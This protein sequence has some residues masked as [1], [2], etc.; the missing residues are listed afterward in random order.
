MA[1]KYQAKMAGY[2]E[3]AGFIA[4][5]QKTLR[6]LGGSQAAANDWSAQYARGR[7]PGGGGT[8]SSSYSGSYRSGPGGGGGAD[9]DAYAKTVGDAY[10][11]AKARAEGRSDLLRSGYR[12]AEADVLGRM[13]GIFDPA[14][15]RQIQRGKERSAATQQDLISKGLSTSTIVPTAQAI[16][17]RETDAALADISSQEARMQSS[18][19]ERIR[20]AGLGQIERENEIYPNLPMH[21][22]AIEDYG[23]YGGGSGSSFSPSG[24]GPAASSPYS[25]TTFSIGGKQPGF[26]TPNWLS[27]TNA[28]YHN[29]VSGRTSYTEKGVTDPSMGGQTR[30]YRP[31][32]KKKT[33]SGYKTLS[34]G[35]N[36]KAGSG[37]FG[38]GATTSGFWGT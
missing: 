3:G 26:S 36:Y 8:S 38:W 37:D 7:T 31:R 5:R 4:N 24:G 29:L 6:A 17:Q 15:Q 21:G 14:R 25:G 18:A 32:R 33:S 9:V 12:Q 34:D 2:S 23:K 20:L 16:N 10:A 28:P 35:S 19:M 11:A 22:A 13:K 30:G 27:K 1:N